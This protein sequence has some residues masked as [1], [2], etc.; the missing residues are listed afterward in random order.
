[1]HELSDYEYAAVEEGSRG[2]AA[3]QCLWVVLRELLSKKFIFLQ[4]LLKLR[5]KL[6]GILRPLELKTD[7]IKKR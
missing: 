6:H 7:V 1:M 5:Q 4:N 3:L 2:A